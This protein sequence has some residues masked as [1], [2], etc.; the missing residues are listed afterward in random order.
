MRPGPLISLASLASLAVVALAGCNEAPPVQAPPPSAA[1]AARGDEVE[2]NKAVIRR[3]VEEA[4]NK[5]N[6]AVADEIYTPDYRG[7]MGAD[8]IDIVKGLEL[9]RA[10][11]AEFLSHR[12]TI[13]DLFGAGDRVV[14][15]WTIDATHNSGKP[16]VLRGMTIS[17]FVDGRI[18]EEWMS[19][20]SQA[21]VNQLAGQ[22]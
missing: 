5:R 21:L 6:L 2:H 17:R 16:V 18:A 9:E 20:D 7:H 12:V 15:R 14:A 8:E 22:P 13:D 10:F 11:H 1:T 3:W 4:H 19:T